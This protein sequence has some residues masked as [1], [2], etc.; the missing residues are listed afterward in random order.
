MILRSRKNVVDDRASKSYHAPTDQQSLQGRSCLGWRSRD[1][2]ATLNKW[3]HSNDLRSLSGG[4]E[5]EGEDWIPE[6]KIH[7]YSLFYFMMCSV[8]K[9]HMSS[10]SGNANN[11]CFRCN[12][13][14][15]FCSCSLSLLSLALIS[16]THGTTASPP[17]QPRA[18]HTVPA[19]C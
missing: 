4:A 11:H 14:N 16:T 12:S 6:G 7:H 10:F 3:L 1:P 5:S 17:S 8:V 15:C 18:G 19:S 2:L 9:V 13:S